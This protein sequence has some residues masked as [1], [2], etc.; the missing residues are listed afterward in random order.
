MLQ[1]GTDGRKNFIANDVRFL[2]RKKRNSSV[3]FPLEATRPVLLIVARHL[4]VI[5]EQSNRRSSPAPEH[6]NTTGKRVFSELALADP[7]K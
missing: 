2:G 4:A 3:T 1:K 6:K 5:A 7:N